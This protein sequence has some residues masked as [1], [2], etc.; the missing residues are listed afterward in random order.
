MHSIEDGN[1]TGTSAC[2]RTGTATRQ[3]KTEDVS[4]Y[5]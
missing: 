1:G 2:T 4:G 5:Y 3:I